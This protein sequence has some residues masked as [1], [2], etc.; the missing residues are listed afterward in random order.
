MV[1]KLKKATFA[2]GCF[3][4]ME[5]PFANLKGVKEVI[6]GYA[7]GE[8]ENPSYEE[9]C[10]GETGHVEAVQII[11][12]PPEI[13][14]EELLDIFWK[15]I[16]PTDEGGQFADRGYQYKTIIFYHNKKQKELAEKSK[17]ELEKSGRYDKPIITEIKK[18]TTFYPAEDYHQDYYRKNTIK[19]K[20]YRYG[21]GRDQ[22][23][24]KV[25]KK[26]I[27]N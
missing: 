2:G 14:Y 15:N 22:Y 6:A 27:K 8:K 18:F 5:P 19:Y 12:D 16:D 24:E 13:T 23:L 10:S 20:M 4:C 11:Y 25:W 17:K 9:V 21:S 7:G 1:N 26:T 3:W